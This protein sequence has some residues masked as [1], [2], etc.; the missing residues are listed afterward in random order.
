[1]TDIFRLLSRSTKLRRHASTSSQNENR[2]PSAGTPTHPQILA[3]ADSQP[4]DEGSLQRGTKRKRKPSSIHLED[5]G[6]GPNFFAGTHVARDSI[7]QKPSSDLIAN[8]SLGT[9]QDETVEDGQALPIGE[10]KKL[11]K[12]HKLKVTLMNSTTQ[13]SKGHKA[14]KSTRVQRMR[15]SPSQAFI[16]IFPD[17]L[18][19]FKELRSNFGVSRRLVQ[20]IQEQGYSVPTEVQ[21]GSL[22]ILL[23]NDTKI[24]LATTVPSTFS[25]RSHV[26]LLTIA[27]T[28]SGK[29][30]AF[31]IPVI[32][33][34][35]QYRY[36]ESLRDFEAEEGRNQVKALIIAPTHE[37]VDQIA[38]EAR[39]LAFGTG[40]KVTTMKKGMR[41]SQT[42]QEESDDKTGAHSAVKSDILV[43]TPLILLN[44]ITQ[45]DSDSDPQPLPSVQFLVLDEADVLLDQL[46]REQTLGIWT[47]CTNPM[48][49][50]SLWSATIGASIED[51][52]RK[53]IIKRLENLGIKHSSGQLIRLIAGLKDSALPSVSHKLVYA[54][55]EAGKLLAIRQLLHPSATSDSHIAALRPPFIVFTQTIERATALHAELLYDI[56]VEAGGS[57]RIAVL[58]SSLSEN[59]RSNIMAG[60]RKGE[61]WIIITTD[62]LA[63]GID[64]RGMNGIVNYDIPNT[65]AGYVHRAGRTGRAGRQG[66]IAVTLYTKEDIPYVKNVA[67][68]IAASEKVMGKQKTDSGVQK[69]LLDALP[70]VSK[71]NKQEL[72]KKGV[73]SRRSAAQGSAS[74]DGRTSRISTKSGFDRRM[75]NNRKGAIASNRRRLPED[76]RGTQDSSSDDEWQ[77]LD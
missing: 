61:I 17:P 40:V 12:A 38:N 46:F 58:H 63:R 18:L 66:G 31:L 54:A 49:R 72:K 45:P 74:K 70:K 27:P 47:A 56:P 67:N 69:W 3:E 50:V 39:K 33:R 32:Q 9:T 42:V 26:D 28:G 21:L 30:L 59:T 57:S 8:R 64:F 11:L 73:E 43:S 13:V 29:T 16:A 55:S 51:L 19:S 77:G 14:K 34:L 36:S 6:E 10:R 15:A 75:L 22:P 4:A 2:I 53:T 60:F 37:L 1:M 44:S 20:N 24:G 48:L 62:L 7:K 68:V 76:M 35:L 52:T 23:G 65:A 71:K 41:V 25:A 5:N